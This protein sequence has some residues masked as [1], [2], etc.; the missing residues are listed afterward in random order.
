MKQTCS[1]AVKQMDLRPK[2]CVGLL[3]SII[4]QNKSNATTFKDNII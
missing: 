1:D 4:K 3:G 2:I